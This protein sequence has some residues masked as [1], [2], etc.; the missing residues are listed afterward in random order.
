MGPKA[1]CAFSRSVSVAV[2]SVVDES[3]SV[4][5]SAEGEGSRMALDVLTERCLYSWGVQ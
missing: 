5:P 4:S 2:W 1:Q 3:M